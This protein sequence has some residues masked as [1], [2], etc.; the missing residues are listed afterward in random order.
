MSVLFIKTNLSTEVRKAMKDIA[1][2]DDDTQKRVRSAVET[3]TKDTYKSAVRHVHTKTGN[4]VSKISMQYNS[5]WNEGVVKSKAHH[6]WLVEHGASATIVLPKKR[7]ALKYDTHFFKLARIPKRAAHPYM[8]PAIDENA[9]K[10]EQ[11]VQEA[12]DRD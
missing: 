4:L 7:R 10:I 11:A 9:P 1:R 8:K 2:Y 6:S 12:V 3:G 5:H